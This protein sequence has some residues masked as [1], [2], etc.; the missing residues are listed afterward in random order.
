MWMDELYWDSKTI[1]SFVERHI[2]NA[3]LIIEQEFGDLKD[4]GC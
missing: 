3:R 4:C 2:P 1:P